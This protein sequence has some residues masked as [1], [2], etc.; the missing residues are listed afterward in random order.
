MTVAFTPMSGP[1]RA[2]ILRKHERICFG[3][4]A[5]DNQSALDDG[6]PDAAAIADALR[7]FAAHGLSAARIA[8]EEALAAREIGDEDAY[9]WWISVC[10]VLD[11]RA[12]AGIE[13]ARAPAV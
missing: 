11:P 12:A 8:G 2:G 10:R 9:G 5:N 1:N 7:H 13:N 6:A 4:P 3:L